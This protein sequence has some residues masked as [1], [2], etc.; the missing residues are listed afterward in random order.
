MRVTPDM[1]T[2]GG[3]RLDKLADFLGLDDTGVQ[4][5]DDGDGVRLTTDSTATRGSSA[6]L[7][8]EDALGVAW[9]LIEH[10]VKVRGRD[11]EVLREAWQ[12]ARRHAMDLSVG[13]MTHEQ[14]TEAAMQLAA[15]FQDIDAAMGQL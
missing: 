1:T 2:E 8:P 7:N 10:A 13:D 12:A 15:A 9:L 11:A 6:W 14:V 3:S 5:S 4:V